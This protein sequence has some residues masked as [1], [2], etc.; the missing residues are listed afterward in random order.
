MQKCILVSSDKPVSFYDMKAEIA[1]SQAHREAVSMSKL[2]GKIYHDYTVQI[3][4][5]EAIGC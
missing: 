4:L 2:L 3:D 1:A 5:L